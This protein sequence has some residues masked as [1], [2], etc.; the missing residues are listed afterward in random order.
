MLH[1]AARHSIDGVE[2]VQNWPMG[3]YPRAN[4]AERIAALRQLYAGFAKGIHR[5]LAAAEVLP[6]SLQPLLVLP[7]RLAGLSP[8]LWDKRFEVGKD[9]LRNSVEWSFV[10]F[11]VEPS[12]LLELDHATP[13]RAMH[14]HL[15][16]NTQRI[17][18]LCRQTCHHLIYG[19]NDV[20]M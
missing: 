14:K 7:G 12:Q 5:L 9:S 11:R 20:D 15:R 6:I 17:R 18:H 8:L 19:I 13:R 16:P 4:E 1:F 10:S 2:L 3:P